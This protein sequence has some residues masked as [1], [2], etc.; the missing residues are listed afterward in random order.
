MQAMR[1]A[2]TFGR[3]A[4]AGSVRPA[5]LPPPTLNFNPQKAEK[6]LL[7]FQS[8]QGEMILINTREGGRERERERE[9]IGEGGGQ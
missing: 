3:R 2:R 4:S 7:F 8:I 6:N 1:C 5:D 9:S